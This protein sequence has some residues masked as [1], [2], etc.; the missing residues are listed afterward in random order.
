MQVGATVARRYLLERE[1]EHDLPGVRRYGARDTRL[2]QAVTVDVITSPAPTLVVASA[3][4]ARVLRDKRLARVLAAGRE[5]VDGEQLSYVVTERPDGVAL[6]ALLGQVAMMPSVAAAVVGEAAA[7]LARAALAGMHH[8]AMRAQAITVTQRGLVKVSGL[9]LD[10][11]LASQARQGRGRSERNDSLALGAIFVEAVTG[12]PVSE[13]SVDDL[14]E[15]LT[16]PARDLAVLAIK[17]RGPTTLAQITRALGSGDASVLRVMALEAPSLWWPAAPA[18]PVVTAGQGEAVAT[19]VTAATEVVTQEAIPADLAVE[20][21][22][23]DD[24]AAGEVVTGEIVADEVALTTEAP[25]EILDAE[26]VPTEPAPQRARTRFGGA[27]DDIDEFHDIVA[28]QNLSPKLSIAE[29]A[30]TRL[31][32][33]FPQSAGLARAVEFAHERASRPAPLNAGPL[34]LG[35]MLTVLFVVG[36]VALS[37]IGKPFDPDYDR[38]N[39]PANTYPAYTFTPRVP[40]ADDEG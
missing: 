32:Q 37:H 23:P 36:I 35:L 14:P 19:E 11:E 5:A 8:G 4:R 18:A 25:G 1:E 20:D 17:G 12:R 21:T 15:D 3:G 24:A 39:N 10:G 29:V 6:D 26:L 28:E 16:E 2:N 34:I 31:Q 9:G 7:G 38:H 40:S 33:R 30:L 27:V 13:V 22:V